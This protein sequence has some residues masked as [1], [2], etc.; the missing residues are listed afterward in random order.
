MPKTMKKNKVK[1]QKLLLQ[2]FDPVLDHCLCPLF[3]EDVL[4]HL[5]E[6][7]VGA[8]WCELRVDL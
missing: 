8:F 7:L 5:P 6:V 1:L 4:S 2:F 3:H